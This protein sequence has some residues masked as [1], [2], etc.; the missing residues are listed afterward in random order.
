MNLLSALV[1]FILVLIAPARADPAAKITVTAF[2]AP[3]PTPTFERVVIAFR[4]PLPTSPKPNAVR[5][6]MYIMRIVDIWNS[7]YHAQHPVA[8]CHWQE[9][10]RI[11]KPFSHN[12]VFGYAVGF[13]LQD[14]VM[15]TA[16]RMFHFG[17]KGHQAVD[18]YQA[19]SSLHGIMTTTAHSPC[20]ARKR[21]PTAYPKASL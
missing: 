14:I 20:C 17:P 9:Y 8:G 13:A 5:Q 15:H 7:A 19:Y 18:G 1:L 2:V 6:T 12:G 4:D 3:T 21:R 10:D 11:M 16:V